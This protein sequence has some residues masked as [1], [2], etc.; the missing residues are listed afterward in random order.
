M[1][2]AY[3][4]PDITI[5]VFDNADMTSLTTSNVTGGIAGVKRTTTNTYTLN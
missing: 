4:A 3:K 1:K 2:K 5:T